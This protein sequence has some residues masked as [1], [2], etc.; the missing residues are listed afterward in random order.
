M[1]LEPST[2]TDQ[3][4][5]APIPTNRRG[6]RLQEHDRLASFLHLLAGV[7]LALFSASHL[8]MLVRGDLSLHLTNVVFPPLTNGTLY[9]LAAIIEMALAFAC[10]PRAGSD[11]INWLIVSFVSVMLLYRWAFTFN[12]GTRCGCLGLLGKLLHISKRAEDWLAELALLLLALT[13]VPWCM[14]GVHSLQR[15]LIRIVPFAL[16]AM[17]FSGSLAQSVIEIHGEYHASHYNPKTQQPYTNSII[18]VAF[19]VTLSG[20][21]WS[22]AATNI[23]NPSRWS[24][25][26]FDGTNTYHFNPY[27]GFFVHPAPQSNMMFVSI[28][29]GPLYQPA[30]NDELSLTIPW[31]T[32]CLSP[33]HLVT[34]EL[35]IVAIPLPWYVPR[36]APKAFGYRWVATATASEPFLTRCDVIRD[37]R[38]DL[39]EKDELIRPGLDYADT[40]ED[41]NHQ[42]RSLQFR[43]ATPDGFLAARYE[44]LDWFRT[45][46]LRLPLRSRFSY[47]IPAPRTAKPIPWGAAYQGELRATSFY[48]L[49][50]MKNILS[51]GPECT[52]LIN[53]YRYTR[54]SPKRI[55]RFAE[56]TLHTG[57]QW[58]TDA[59]PQLLAAVEEHIRHGP[60]FDSVGWPR[61]RNILSWLVLAAI[62]AL[63]VIAMILRKTHK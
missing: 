15:R 25:L 57:E 62:P 58:K 20:S 47:Y 52:A 18:H 35:G 9:F 29:P 61:F 44:C 45:N 60:R 2:Q 5:A 13:P 21:Y 32:Y 30:V 36:L 56:Y 34:N 4:R 6:T 19:T 55:F 24:R 46:E 41:Q 17:S 22:I 26:V 11:A 38:L 43:L 42:K 53:D 8:A 7:M 39:K 31:L 48:M 49:K 23:D 14:R 33:N 10:L 37:V 27:E 59:D 16:A 50:E 54:R 40:V 28:S 12:G 1:P 63:S 51:T 3:T